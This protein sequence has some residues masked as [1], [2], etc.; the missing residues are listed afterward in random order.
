[1][2]QI[3]KLIIKVAKKL[4]PLTP[5]PNIKLVHSLHSNPKTPCPKRR[6]IHHQFIIS[7]QL[8]REKQVSGTSSLNH[9]NLNIFVLT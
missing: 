5:S 1:M 3:Q 8:K 4:S 9:M 6:D 7:V 2:F